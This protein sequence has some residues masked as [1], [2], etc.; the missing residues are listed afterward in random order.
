V[1]A[2][3]AAAVS[4]V[5]SALAEQADSDKAEGMAVYMKTD[6]PFYGVQKPARIRVLRHI[7]REFAPANREEYEELATALWELP[8]REEKYVAQ[9]V[10]TI[11]SQHIVPESLPLYERFI[12]EGAWWDFVDDTATHMIRELVLN[13]PGVIWPVVDSWIDH[14]SMWRRR[15]AVIC[16]VGA[17]DRTDADRLFAYCEARAHETEFFIRKAIGWALREYAKTDAEAVA[18]FVNAHRDELSGLS[19]R[20]ATKHI[21]E[22][23]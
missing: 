15:A 5:Q 16:Q 1:S 10:A 21:E 6:M 2:K 14:E 23:V 7:K 9:G 17:K 11:F 3:T 19:Y 12:D 8:H 4:Y 18:G 20:E 22:L 13:H